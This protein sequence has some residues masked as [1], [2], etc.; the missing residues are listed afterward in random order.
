[1]RERSKRDKGLFQTWVRLGYIATTPG[2]VID[3]DFILAAIEEDSQRYDLREI[4]FDRWGSSQIVLKLQDK[5]ITVIEIGQGF[6]SMSAPMKELERQILAAGLAHGG[7]PV[8]TWMAGNL[9]ARED[10]AGNIKPDREASSEKID[11]MVSLIMGLARAMLDMPSVYDE[12]GVL[13][14]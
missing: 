4:G 7:N 6:A 2:N 1:M 14:V 5:G 8:L 10:P 11:G 9:V 12:R 3:Y 13:E